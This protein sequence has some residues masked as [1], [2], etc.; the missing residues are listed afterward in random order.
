MRAAAGVVSVAL[1]LATAC[2]R[3]AL[4][5]SEPRRPF[6]ERLRR[7]EAQFRQFQEFTLTRLQETEENYNL[8]HNLHT[9]MDQL[10][11]KHESLQLVANGSRASTQEELHRLQTWVKK[12]ERNDK[13]QA[14]RIRALEEGWQETQQKQEEQQLESRLSNLTQELERHREDFRDMAVH[15]QSLQKTLQSLQDALRSQGSKLGSIEQRLNS[16]KQKEALPSPWTAAHRFRPEKA[17]QAAGGQSPTLKKLRAKHR[18]P[19]GR[20]E[21]LAERGSLLSQA[22]SP[23]QVDPGPASSPEQQTLAEQS[24]GPAKV[25]VEEKPPGGPR[26]PGTRCNVGAMLV[27]PNASTENF[28]AFQPSLQTSLLELSLCSWVRTSARYLGTIL[29]YATEENDNKLVLHGRDAAPRNSIHF[30]IGDPAFRELPVGAVLDGRWHHVCVIW[31]SL[32]G[33]YWFYLDRRLASLGSNFRKGYEIP[34]Q[35]SLLLGQEQDTLG[36]GF[37]SSESFVGLLAGF[38]M[39]GRALLPGEVSSIALGEGLPRG[40]V[41]TLANVSMLSGSVQKVDCTCLEHCL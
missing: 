25:P 18:Q 28:A 9:K 12:L 10:L 5:Q 8:S 13:K 35:G 26:K 14:L 21:A 23:L 24:P 16:F 11:Q 2:L 32:Q 33:R 40:T 1:V 30:V 19:G 39:W 6:F 4:M 27:F 17:S 3:G 20:L 37:E 38:A 29:S 15:Q 36:G 34:S 31:S 22:A 41:L 7:L